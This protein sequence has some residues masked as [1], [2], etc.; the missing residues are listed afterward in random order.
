MRGQ[1]MGALDGPGQGPRKAGRGGLEG[2]RDPGRR[3]MRAWTVTGTQESGAW[4]AWRVTGTQEGS[5]TGPGAR[6]KCLK[7]DALEQRFPEPQSGPAPRTGGPTGSG[8]LGQAQFAPPGYLA[9]SGDS[10]G[11]S[12][13]RGV[14][15]I[16]VS[17]GLGAA[18]APQITQL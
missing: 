16:L 2:H 13:F 12:Q 4:G 7:G 11:S 10:L 14:V 18:G 1:R 3:D 5:H 9:P 17:R 8:V 6:R 15:G